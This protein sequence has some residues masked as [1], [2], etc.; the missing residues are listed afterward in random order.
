MR[1][2]G[3]Y[4]V[5]NDVTAR[6]LQRRTSQWLAGKAIDTFAPMGPGIVP[7][8]EVPDPQA[9]ELITRLNGEVVQQAS[10]RDMIFSVA[11]AISFISTIMSLE[12]GD[13]IATGTPSGVGSA[14]SPPRFLAPGDRIEVE[15]EAIG[16]IA[17]AVLAEPDGR[18]EW[19]A[20]SS[21]LGDRVG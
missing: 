2:I 13:I 15:I 16:T 1:Y 18:R 5:F 12:P 6:D 3:G 4:T 7:A 20:N 10:T 17:N 11:A 21:A 14:Q 9:L 19:A 8:F